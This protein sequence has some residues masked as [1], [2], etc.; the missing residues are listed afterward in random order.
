MV[1]R[2]DNTPRAPT[3]AIVGA[4]FCGTL[5]AVWL[6]KSPL[7]STARILL[8]ERG[9]T[10]GR[11]IA[12]R[13]G[14]EHWLLNVPAERM[15]PF[16]D[17]PTDFL[18]WARR[19]DPSIEA[20]DFLPRSLYGDYLE[21]LLDNAAKAAG[22]AGPQLVRIR[23]AVQGIMPAG[24]HARLWLSDGGSVVADR[25]VLAL[26]NPQPAEPLAH[27][28][29][30]PGYVGE[31]WET[32]WLDGLGEQ[33][34]VALLGT[35]LTTL[36]VALSVAKA[37]PK[38]RILA[39]S[40]H[41]LLPREQRS[42]RQPSTDPLQGEVLFSSEAALGRG[43][44]SRRL[45]RLREFIARWSGVGGDWRAVIQR[46]REAFPAL[47]R[48]LS[49]RDRRRFLR[50]LRPWW[51][52]HRHRVPPRTLE[53]FQSLRAN[54]QVSI[55]AARLVEAWSENGRAA[56]RWLPRGGGE[57]IVDHA[58]AIVNCTGPDL[59]VRRSRCPLV[60]SLV[61][62]RLARPDEL[63]L[64]WQ[65][66]EDGRLVDAG[67]CASSLLYYVGPLLRGRSWEATAVPELRVHVERTA[68][69]LLK[70][71]ESAF[72][73]RPLFRI[74]AEPPRHPATRLLPG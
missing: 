30:L 45:R 66:A 19:R 2:I 35:G 73:V 22:P 20:G 25:V 43:P 52:V 5:M 58:D 57:S 14:P 27:L 29:A 12:Y 42:G 8:I 72:Q 26:G 15:S 37:R 34:R 1:I 41:G 55:G 47:W 56:L 24:S 63:G 44:L 33:P 38:A 65:T 3:I 48:D 9:D 49:P 39:F 23:A 32:E 51:D 67:G 61:E 40:R 68:A 50:H 36:D 46:T 16:A 60:Q 18:D 70:S 64:G 62:Q 28:H 69:A 53:R 10:F 31:P 11:G 71:L 6:M 17:R 74:T 13:K 4:G 21:A 59:S 54:G 7:Q